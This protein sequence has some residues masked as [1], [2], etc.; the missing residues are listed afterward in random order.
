MRR[1][2]GLVLC[3]AFVSLFG[4]SGGDGNGSKGD[5]RKFRK[6][7]VVTYDVDVV[8]IIEWRQFEY[9]SYGNIL[10]STLYGAAGADGKWQTADDVISFQSRVALDANG[11]SSEECGIQ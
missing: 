4:C 8:T 1:V 7:R 2:L 6:D 5:Y 9:D 10:K 11:G 3:C